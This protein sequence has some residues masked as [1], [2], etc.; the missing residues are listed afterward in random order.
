M[1]RLSASVVIPTYNRPDDLARCLAS[2]VGQTRRPDQVIVID[3]GALDVVPG[4]EALS[5]AGIE[6]I[7]RRKTAPGVTESRNLGIALARGAIVFL[8]E[9]DVILEP[10]YVDAILTVFETDPD[11]A[12]AGVGGIVTNERRG[13]LSSL[14]RQ[15]IY[16]PLYL[17]AV[18]EGRMLRSGFAGEYGESPLAIRH[19][20]DVDF[21]IGGVSAFRRDRLTGIEFSNRFR[22]TTGY[23][24]G[25]DKDFSLRVARRGRLV[26]Q[27]GARLT[28]HP[29]QKHKF[30]QRVRGRA[31]I[32]SKHLLFRT[33]LLERWWHWLPFGYALVSYTLLRLVMALVMFRRSE[34]QRVRGTLDGWT[35]IL[36]GRVGPHL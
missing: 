12:I 13:P 5:A 24:Q 27:P 4:A 3:D 9:D 11:G 33:H 28:H 19:V 35:A 34:W 17:S 21:L 8:S 10:G 16:V 22:S 15:I 32:I 29:A 6:L 30:N 2:L 31:V 20:R 25:E 14:L 23:G 7:Y 1:S 18:N 36:T 26:V